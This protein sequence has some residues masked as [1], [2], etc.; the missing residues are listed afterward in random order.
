MLVTR[1][2]DYR[3]TLASRG[4]LSQAAKPKAFVSI[5][6]NA[7]STAP[8]SIP[9]SEVYHQVASA[10]SRRLGGLIYEE[11]TRTLSAYQ[12]IV[13]VAG[14]DPGVKTRLDDKGDD[15][16]GVVRR[17]R[18]SPGVLAELAFITNPT[19]ADLLGRGR[20]AAGRG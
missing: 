11:I 16:Y 15:Y 6:H 17:T 1:T 18:G 2:A 3:S 12:G 13:W 10:Q 8:S 19:E 9:G 4:L 14:R 7:G 5:H 20:R